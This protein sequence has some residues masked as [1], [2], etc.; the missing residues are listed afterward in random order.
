MDIATMAPDLQ[1]FFTET[2]E[3]T[4]RASKLVQRQSKLTGA[5]FCRAWSLALPITRRHA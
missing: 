1:A 5:V 3:T 2:A 4:A